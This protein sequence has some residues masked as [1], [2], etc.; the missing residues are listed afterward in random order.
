MKI[1]DWFKT[2]NSDADDA[3]ALQMQRN[4][5]ALDASSSCFM[6]A[7][8][9]RVIIYANIAVKKLLKIVSVD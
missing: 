7:D 2:G 3:H 4:S 8:E 6:M 5:Q 1:L 9:N